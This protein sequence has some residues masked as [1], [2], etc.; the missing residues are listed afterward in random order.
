M[1][2]MIRIQYEILAMNVDKMYP[3]YY[4]LKPGETI[5][6]HL[7]D[8]ETF[9]YSCGWTPE[10]YLEEYIHRAVEEYFPNPAKQN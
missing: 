3:P 8:V 10:Q 4:V 5:D 7:L 6:E 2:I 1:K 9:I